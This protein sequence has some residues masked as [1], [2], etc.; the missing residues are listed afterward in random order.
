MILN[1]DLLISLSFS[2]NF[3]EAN[4]KLTCAEFNESGFLKI[5]NFIWL[6]GQ[7]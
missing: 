4:V 3:F 5:G 7:L 6:N 2:S 1:N